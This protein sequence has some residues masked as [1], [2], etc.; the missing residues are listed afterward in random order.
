MVPPAK[1]IEYAYSEKQKHKAKNF[2]S[3]REYWQ[4]DNLINESICCPSQSN[5][6][7]N[8]VHYNIDEGSYF[9]M[10]ITISIDK[11]KALKSVLKR[12]G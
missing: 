1:G 11:F 6:M 9:K 8:M 5:N 2:N 3:H 7:T 10:S 12:W 4:S